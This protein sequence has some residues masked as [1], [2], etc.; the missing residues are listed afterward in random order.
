MPRHEEVM[1]Q[2]THATRRS[3]LPEVAWDNI[4]DPGAYVERGSGDL[5]RFP[6]GIAAAGGA[7]GR[8]EGVARRFHAGQIER[9]SLCNNTQGSTALRP[10]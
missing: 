5:Y 10:S 4:N 9:R 3:A 2:S 6:P 1:T 8:G 7:S